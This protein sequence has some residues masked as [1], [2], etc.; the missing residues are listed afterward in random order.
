MSSAK[1]KRTNQK[2]AGLTAGSAIRLQ[3]PHSSRHHKPIVMAPDIHPV[4]GFLQFLREHTVVSLAVGFAIATQAQTVIKQ[5]ISSFIDPLYGLLFSQKLSAKALTVHFHGRS[6]S[7]AWGA[8]V[9]TF[10]DFLFVL[11]VIYAIVKSLQL[12]K[13]DKPVHKSS[14]PPEKKTHSQVKSDLESDEEDKFVQRRMEEEIK[15]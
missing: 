13:L 2:P 9:Y 8:F 11:G 7:F 4:T 10:V 14:P 12:D 6:Q 5:L 3:P 1:R 15:L